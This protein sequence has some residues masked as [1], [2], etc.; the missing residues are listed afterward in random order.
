[1]EN[2]INLTEMTEQ[3]RIEM[4]AKLRKQAQQLLNKANIVSSAK[5]IGADEQRI[6]DQ[7]KGIGEGE[8]AKISAEDVPTMLNMQPIPIT[9]MDLE[10]NCENMNM[11]GQGSGQG[12]QKI[13]PLYMDK[14][15]AGAANDKQRDCSKCAR[16]GVNHCLVRVPSPRRLDGSCDFYLELTKLRELRFMVN[17]YCPICHNFLSSIS[18]SEPIKTARCY[19]CAVDIGGIWL[20]KNCIIKDMENGERNSNKK[21]EEISSESA[22][23]DGI[24]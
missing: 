11:V 3:E 19:N 13:H 18:I 20:S 6:I 9:P 12:S 23:A 22:K 15:S 16:W 14:W 4:A 5:S 17:V 10:F 1:M 8:M 7:I 21:I 2:R 24:N